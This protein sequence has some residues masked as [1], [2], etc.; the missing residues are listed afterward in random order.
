MDCM[1]D[2]SKLSAE[3]NAALNYFAVPAAAGA[4]AGSV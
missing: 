4:A 3:Q 2:E 1:T